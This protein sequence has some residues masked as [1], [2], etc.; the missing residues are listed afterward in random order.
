M[1]QNA[2]RVHGPRNVQKCSKIP[3]LRNNSVFNQ[4]THILV[5]T[6]YDMENM[7]STR[8]EIQTFG[9]PLNKVWIILR[10]KMNVMTMKMKKLG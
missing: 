4:K 8:E 7:R 3:N 9:I 1:T 2:P 6:T 5:G 10:M